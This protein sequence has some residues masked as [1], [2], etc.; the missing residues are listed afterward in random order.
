[1]YSV[2]VGTSAHD[3]YAI[4]VAGQWIL[5]SPR[6][7]TSVLVNRAAVR[8][9]AAVA[10]GDKPANA[11]AVGEL[12]R[13]LSTPLAPPPDTPKKLVIIPT[14]L[15]NMRCAYC[16]FPAAGA[17][18]AVLDPRL[19]CRLIDDVVSDLRSAAPAM[20]R[21]HFFGGEPLVARRCV[22]T[23]VHYARLA[24][25]RAGLVPWFEITTNGLFDEAAVP[26]LGDDM[27]SVVVSVDGDEPA[28]DAIRRTA[29]GRGTH[30][31]IAANIRRLGSFPVE[32][33]LRACVTSR[34]VG[35]MVDIASRFC[36][37]FD[38]DVLSFEMLAPNRIAAAAGLAPPDPYAFAAGFL[39]AE[40]LAAAHGVR[41]V[42]GPS[43]LTTPRET[44][45]PVGLGTLMLNPDGLLTACYLS[46]DRWTERGLDPVLGRVDLDSGSVVSREKLDA[47][48]GLLKQKPRCAR[49]F[50]R[51]SCAGGCHIDH[52]PPGCS[53]EYDDRCRAIRA[54][55]AGRLLRRLKGRAAAE[56][57]AEAPDS[58][59]ALAEHPDDRLTAWVRGP[60]QP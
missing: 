46:V 28:H 20:L 59:R 47:V 21:I 36:A 50:C 40:S 11:E 39:K 6:S 18:P 3:V 38:F 49:C 26:F 53:L 42:H 51:H 15:C 45:C 41:V 58:M 8:A 35:S 7:T 13:H 44:S 23:I 24:C 4:P 22:E 54:V 56:Q 34:T 37:E 19:A 32:L 2:Q 17:Q 29:D 60:G 31:A 25:A 16:D 33:S 5:H 48:A 14:R 1:M 57:F 12:W 30:A 52:T 55:T 9:V 27:D 10:A 43:E